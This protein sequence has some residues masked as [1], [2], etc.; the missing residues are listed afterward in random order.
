[1]SDLC[2]SSCFSLRD[3]CFFF[4]LPASTGASLVESRFLFKWVSVSFVAG[5]AN[6][7]VWPRI[8]K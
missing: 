8:F 6:W 4:C 2:L 3:L 7:C 5:S 1:L